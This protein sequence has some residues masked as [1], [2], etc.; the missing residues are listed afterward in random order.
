M[1]MD[2]TEDVQQAV[3]ANKAIIGYRESLSYI[4]T[5]KPKLIVMSNNL[6]SSARKEIE[7]NSKI[8]KIKL[9]TFGGTSRDLG[10][11]CGKPFP[12][13]TLVIKG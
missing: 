1:T 2:V 9:E 6:P 5:S 12:V 8:S 10:V 3:K 11:I 4:K 7:H 13:S